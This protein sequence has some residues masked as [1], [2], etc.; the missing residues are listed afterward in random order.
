MIKR[1]L[2]L[3]FLCIFFT[4]CGYKDEK[5]VRI[6]F[7]TWGSVSE[8]N[9]LKPIISDFEKQNPGIKVTLQH[10]PQDYF[11]KLH[12]LF[13]SN[14]EPDVIFVNNLN[15][16]VYSNRLI[17]LT[18]KF[19]DKLYYSQGIKCLS[20]ADKI[21]A[22]PRDIS[23]LIVY[24]NKDLFNK[25]GIPYPDKNWKIEDLKKTAQKLT[26]KNHFGISFEP[27][28]YYA[29]PYIRYFNSDILDTDLNL[30]TDKKEFLKDINYYKNF[31]YKYHIAPI[32]S[33]V[34]SKTL[35]QMFI[36]KKIAMHISGRWLTPKYRQSADFNWDIVNFPNC[37]APTDA[38][39]W[40]ITK[41]SK[42]KNE[43]LKFIMFLSSKE[44]ISKMTKEGLIIPARKDVANSKYFLNGKPDNSELFIYAIENST[45]T[46][47]N[48]KYNKIVDELNDKYFSE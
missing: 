25:Y 22:I 34:G 37:S 31:A 43:A 26:D 29:M 45:I 40:A 18:D 7:S 13:A 16:P 38:S 4:G 23:V 8:L 36:E 47:V 30:Q 48:K 11:K 5:V 32:P 42:H 3:F 24:Y 39:G 33:Q 20:V 27:N 10:I 21:Y 6:T 41:A 14:L 15:L 28:I 2:T 9:I 19:D 35:A 1:F 12:L 46:N 44:N 17:D